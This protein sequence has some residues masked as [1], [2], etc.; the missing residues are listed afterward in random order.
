MISALAAVTAC[1]NTPAP[2]T[3]AN[4]SPWSAK[5][6]A[7]RSSVPDE[8]V[9]EDTA[10]EDGAMKDEPAPMEAQA[11][12]QAEPVPQ[13]AEQ[14]SVENAPVEA[15]AA[16]AAAPAVE[17]MTPEQ[18]I[19]AMSPGAYAVQVYAGKTL[20]SI[21]KFKQANGLDDLKTVKTDRG[22]EIVYVL[23]SLQPDRASAKQA[24]AELE[25]KT[26]TK[27]WVRSIAGLQKI[28]A[29]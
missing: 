17:N 13:A 5:H 10:M 14:E 2:W 29:Q 21:D 9:V 28:V 22:G 3:Q 8:A 27:P 1:S 23:V 4:Q 7:E 12:P 11:E 18:E 25:Q 19:L 24:A 16:E 15:V 26:G 20:A 6:E